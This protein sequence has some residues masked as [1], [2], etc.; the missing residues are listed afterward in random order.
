[1]YWVVGGRL[2]YKETMA[3]LAERVM[4][5]EIGQSFPEFKII[6]YSN[7]IFPDENLNLTLHT[8][9]SSKARDYGIK[10]EP[11][12]GSF[13]DVHLNSYM[14]NDLSL[15][16]NLWNRYSIFFNVNNMLDKKYYTSNWYSQ[17]DRSVNFGIKRSY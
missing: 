1:M 10:I 3:E 12:N 7:Y 11:A 14:V 15:N 6:G 17:M 5:Q 4:M 9:V 13:D 16:Y 2:R 8:K